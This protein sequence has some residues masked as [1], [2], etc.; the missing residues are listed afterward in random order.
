MISSTKAR[1]VAGGRLRKVAL[2][3]RVKVPGGEMS[4]TGMRV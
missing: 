2:T 4:P 1:A 3:R